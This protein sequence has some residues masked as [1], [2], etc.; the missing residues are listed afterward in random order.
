[1]LAPGFLKA[2]KVLPTGPSLGHPLLGELPALDLREDLSHGGPH[3]II[4]DPRPTGQVAVLSG[5]RHRVA[6]P[7]DALLVDE[8]HDEFE[9]VE[10]FEIADLGLVARVDQ[11]VERAADQFCDPAAKDHLLAE[12]VGLTLLGEGGLD[13]S[14][15]SAPQ[16]VRVGQS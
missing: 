9:F 2:S 1:M 14:G 12:Q 6:H 7:A 16:A 5:V 13:Y 15:P 8:V 11:S 3:P 10:T 4:D